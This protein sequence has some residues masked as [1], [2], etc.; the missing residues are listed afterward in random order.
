MAWTSPRTWFAGEKPTADIMNVHIRDNLRAL[1]EARRSGA[2]NSITDASGLLVVEHGGASTPTS[3]LM[4]GRNS[5]H[6]PYLTATTATTFTVRFLSRAT[7]AAL[8]IPTA[9]AFDWSCDFS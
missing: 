9:V 2:V 7:G 8:T 6:Y 5:G 3:V 4:S 1:R